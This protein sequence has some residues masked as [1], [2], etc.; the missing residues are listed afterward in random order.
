MINE[1]KILFKKGLMTFFCKIN[2][3]PVKAVLIKKLQKIFTQYLINPL[4][5]ILLGSSV[6]TICRIIRVSVATNS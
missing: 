5:S 3:Y 1:K 2:G 6:D 4:I